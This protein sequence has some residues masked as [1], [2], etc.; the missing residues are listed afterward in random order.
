MGQ[1]RLLIHADTHPAVGVGHL[2]R[3]LSLAEAWAAVGGEVELITQ[4]M[5]DAF[6]AAVP[7]GVE[8]TLVDDADLVDRIARSSSGP[9]WLVLD[10]YRLTPTDM[11]QATGAGRLAVLR[12]HGMAVPSTA[13][14]VIDP[15]EGAGAH[16][17]AASAP[18]AVVLAGSGYAL[19]RR[20]FYEARHATAPTTTRG[21]VMVGG[22]PSELVT[23]LI[24]ETIASLGRSV[25]VLG[26]G[27]DGVTLPDS[28]TRLTT[29]ADP[30]PT[31]AGRPWALVPAGSTVWELCC[32]GVPA[33]VYAAAPNQ[34]R[35]GEAV[36]DAGVATYLGPVEDLTAGV[37]VEAIELLAA[38]E[39]ARL[40]MARR[41]SALVDGAGASRVV[42]ELMAV[43]IE[44]RPAQCDD[45]A[46]LFEWAN[47]P[48]VR[49]ASFSSD[50][51]VWDDHRRW[52]H[53]R[54]ADPDHQ[55]FIGEVEQ[56]PIGQ[57][58]FDRVDCDHLRVGVSLAAAARGRHLAAPFIAA[59][60]RAALE[61][62]GALGVIAEI[63]PENDRSAAA[64]TT[65]AYVESDS[66]PEVLRLVWRV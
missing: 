22:S 21:L 10:S 65:A 7:V 40:D 26:S 35:V 50:P 57:I 54:L 55:L 4:R 1:Q 12:D 37:V 59:G 16:S 28:V 24:A 17:Y 9:N 63:R 36:A 19:L 61:H 6:S 41:G 42:A 39:V 60:T 52:L 51:I 49:A 20:G 53:D 2:I 8:V 64:F 14:M 25:D 43:D 15:N 44:L 34:E 48:A 56:E 23:E 11:E 45:A 30:A 13:A 38:D 32:L 18:G 3:C 47:D 46:L 29:T 66:D 31:M 33:V 58:R 5:P 62:S 27:L